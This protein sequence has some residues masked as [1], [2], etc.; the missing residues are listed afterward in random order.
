[1]R[2]SF[3]ALVLATF[4]GSGIAAAQGPVAHGFSVGLLP[5]S[6]TGHVVYPG[7]LGDGP[8]APDLRVVGGVAGLPLFGSWLVWGTAGVDLLLPLTADAAGSPVRPYAGVGA[9]AWLGNPTD[10]FFALSASGLLGVA[11]ALP[12]FELF[13]EARG[14]VAYAFD[15]GFL[16]WPTVAVGVNLAR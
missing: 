9:A 14:S 6:A 2:S 7:A 8:G 12:A 16:P 5:L 11:V 3:T 10:A 15:G 13:V 4:L 1:V